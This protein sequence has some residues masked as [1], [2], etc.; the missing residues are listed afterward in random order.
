[1]S[2]H[3]ELPSLYQTYHIKIPI[4]G[5]S[6][7]HWPSP[8]P[9]SLSCFT[10]LHLFLGQ[11]WDTLL[12][13]PAWEC[14]IL[15]NTTRYFVCAPTQMV[16]RTRTSKRS[17]N[18]VSMGP[19]LT[20]SFLFYKTGLPSYANRLYSRHYKMCG[21]GTLPTL[22]KITRTFDAMTEEANRPRSKENKSN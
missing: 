18:Y 8:F 4:R 3:S 15:G 21:P 19:W 20:H 6:G 5:N 1:M 16:G 2:Q 22:V 13:R 11:Y 14:S 9:G 12:Y 17:M 7:H 10:E